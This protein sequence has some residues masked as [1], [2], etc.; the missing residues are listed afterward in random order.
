MTKEQRQIVD[1][2]KISVYYCEDYRIEKSPV[3]DRWEVFNH[4]FYGSFKTLQEARNYCRRH[5]V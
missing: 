2:Q 4:G 5:A 3:T 1:V